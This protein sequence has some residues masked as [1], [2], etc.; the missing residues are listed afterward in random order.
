[1]TRVYN[2]IYTPEEYLNVNLINLDIIEDFLEEYQQRKIKKTTL[3]QYANDLRIIA[4]FT[5]RFCDNKSF[6]DLVKRDFRKM[7]IWLS[8]DLSMSNARV[9]RIMSACRSMLTY[10]EDSDEYSYLNNVAKKVKGL[11]ITSSPLPMYKAK[12]D[13]RDGWGIAE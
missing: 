7:S 2:K 1:M 8:D 12:S 3:E 4:L 5:K 6:L 13:G 10:I 11:V 9:N